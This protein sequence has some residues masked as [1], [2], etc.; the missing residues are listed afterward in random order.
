MEIIERIGKDLNKF[1]IVLTLFSGGENAIEWARQFIK[2]EELKKASKRTLILSDMD[3]P[4]ESLPYADICGC[5][6]RRIGREEA[7]AF[8]R[9]YRMYEFSDQL[10]MISDQPQYGGLLNYVKTGVMTL[11]EIIQTLL[12]RG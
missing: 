5:T 1:D 8:E 7:E 9:L 11:E 2:S 12:N 4:C 10:I 3:L 6:Y